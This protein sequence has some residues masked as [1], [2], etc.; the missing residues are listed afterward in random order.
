MGIKIQPDLGS[1]FSDSLINHLLGMIL[2]ALG[3]SFLASF[4]HAGSL[5]PPSVDI[6]TCCAGFQL[7]LHV[8]FL[9][10]D[11]FLV[12]LLTLHCTQRLL[13]RL[14][15]APSAV[16]L[17]RPC[18]AHQVLLVNAFWFLSYGANGVFMD[19]NLCFR[20]IRH[21]HMPW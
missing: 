16:V 19:V 6:A 3:V 8:F 14:R 5:P 1:W 11:H 20:P 10:P 21:A 15:E 13:Q 4:F 18:K 17:L 12:S 7:R 2:R 9:L